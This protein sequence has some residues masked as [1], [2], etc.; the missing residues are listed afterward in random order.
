MEQVFLGEYIRQRRKELGLTQAKLC[1]GI[2]DPMTV[3]R[4]ERG[5]QAP[6][7][8]TVNSLLQRLGL[9]GSRYLALLSKK[10]EDAENLRKSVV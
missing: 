5:R 10:E 6:A 2:C 1:E 3:S 7:Y 4:L 8:N 9:P